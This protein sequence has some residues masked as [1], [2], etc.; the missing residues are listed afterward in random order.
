MVRSALSL[1]FGGFLLAVCLS[2]FSTDGL[3]AQTSASE[4]LQVLDFQQYRDTVEPIF[5]TRRPGN[6]RCIVCHSRGGGNSFLEPLAPGR[7]SYDEEQ[8]F[9]NF[10]RI[11]RLVVPGEPMESILLVNPL[12]EDAGGSHWHAGG[13]HWE[14]QRDAEWRA[15][16]AWVDNTT[17]EVD[18]DYYRDYVEPIFLTRRPGNARCIVCHSRGG[19]NS[20][21]E[22]L[23]P[24]R[25]AYDE[26]QSFRNFERVRGLVVPGAP[27]ESILLVN[28]L[29]EDAGGSHW[30][31]GGKH[32]TTQAADEWQTLSAWVLGQSGSSR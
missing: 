3:A 14:S 13:K 25:D 12:E 7:D 22:P 10:E 15:L 20:F 19:G 9:R 5:L 6:A 31:A 29:S 4:G 11:Q 24:G 16:A 17:L 32:W 2:P 1:A 28:P 18:F 30:H 8:S 23:A 27:L 21:L 26:E